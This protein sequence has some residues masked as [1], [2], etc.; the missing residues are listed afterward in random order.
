MEGSTVTTSHSLINH[1]RSSFPNP[2]LITNTEPSEI[3]QIVPTISHRDRYLFTQSRH[4]HS[5]TQTFQHIRILLALLIIRSWILD[6]V[7]ALACAICQSGCVS[8]VVAC[9]SADGATWGVTLGL[10]ASAAV[11]GYKCS[12]SSREDGHDN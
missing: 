1:L 3:A 6:P 5:P 2:S 4:S 12:K 8:V 11:V 7:I 10:T 9:Y